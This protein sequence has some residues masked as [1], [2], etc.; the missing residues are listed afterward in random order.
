VS[1]NYYCSIANTMACHNRSNTSSTP[2]CEGNTCSLAALNSCGAVTP[3]NG[4]LSQTDI[5]AIQNV[6]AALFKDAAMTIP[7]FNCSNPQAA[8]SWSWV[9][10]SPDNTTIVTVDI[11]NRN[12]FGQISPYVGNLT[13][14]TQLAMNGNALTGTIPLSLGNLVNLKYLDLYSNQL[15]GS[16]PSVL[17]QLPSIFALYVQNNL[18]TGQIPDFVSVPNLAQFMLFNNSGL[19][20]CVNVPRSV[21]NS[22]YYCSILG[23]QACHNRDNST[24]TTGIAYCVGNTCSQTQWA[25]CNGVN[26]TNTIVPQGGNSIQFAPGVALIAAL[27]VALALVQGGAL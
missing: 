23:T 18:L 9:Q 24:Q 12:A 3:Q 1:S 7:L 4:S 16:L 27:C 13:N 15:S 22:S 2:W 6:C 8:C 11:S 17:G 10:C 26:G 14:L 19:T 25:E 5:V 21:V 20:G